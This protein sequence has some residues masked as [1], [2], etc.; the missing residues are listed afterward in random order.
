MIDFLEVSVK[1]EVL[2]DV[3]FGLKADL[4]AGRR[5]L[6]RKSRLVY[7]LSPEVIG[8]GG[9][10]FIKPVWDIRTYPKRLLESYLR[11]LRFREWRRVI[12]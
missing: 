6:E 10:I 4:G 2:E 12:K 9:N 11:H 7:S 5:T 3:S 1:G 8:N